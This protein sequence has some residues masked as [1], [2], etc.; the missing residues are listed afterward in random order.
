[1][2]TSTNFT[3]S[4]PQLQSFINDFFNPLFIGA[5]IPQVLLGVIAA[6]TCRYFGRFGTKDSK[7]SLCVAVL[8]IYLVG[9]L[10]VLNAFEDGMIMLVL[11]QISGNVVLRTSIVEYFENVETW[12]LWAQPGITLKLH[13]AVIVFLTQFPFLMWYWKVMK[14]S[15]VVLALLLPVLLLSLGCG[16]ASSISLFMAKLP[17]FAITTLMLDWL[18]VI[19]LTDMI[20]VVAMLV[21]CAR[22]RRH[23]VLPIA[24][25]SK[26]ILK[27]IPQMMVSSS[28]GVLSAILYCAT[29]GTAYYLVP[30]FSISRVHTITVLVA[31]LSFQADNMADCPSLSISPAVM[32]PPP[33]APPS[34]QDRNQIPERDPDR[35]FRTLLAECGF[36]PREDNRPQDSAV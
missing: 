19:S 29:P 17:V 5:I 7:L 27:V 4:E 20:L 1:M 30:Q 28:L 11:V 15:W 24:V 25:S 8:P 33:P 9:V 36:I 35:E 26:H 6:L 22:N 31:L 34:M 16:L 21:L 32:N 10:F 23:P 13:Q 12:T 3:L 2:A 18:A 14:K